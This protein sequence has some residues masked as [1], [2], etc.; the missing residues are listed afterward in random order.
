[1]PLMAAAVE[2]LRPYPQLELIWASPREILNIFQADAIGCQIITVTNDVL[3][4]LPLVGKDLLKYSQETVA[5]FHAD[6]VAAAY[7]LTETTSPVGA[8]PVAQVAPQ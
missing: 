7:T 4:K 3:K 6:A 5:M 2:L 8:A 1:V